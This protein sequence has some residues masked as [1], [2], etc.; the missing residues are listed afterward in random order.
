MTPRTLFLALQTLA[1]V[2]G[3]I[4]I[5][6]LY[7][8]DVMFSKYPILGEDDVLGA[9]SLVLY[10]LILMPLVKYVL[11]VLWANDDG[12][13]GIFAMYSLICRNA[14]VSLIPN[15]QLQA[16]KRMSSFRLK[17]PTPELER[18][19]KVKEK[20]ES[21]PL[22]KK[23][24][25]GLVLFGTA[26]FI[27][28]GVITPAMSVLSAVSGLKVGIPHASQDIVVMISIALLVV[29]YSLQRYA[30]SKIGF[31]V[32]P[33]LLIWF[34]C[35]GGIGI[36]NLSRYGPAA[37]KA[38]N[39]LYIIHF[40]GRNPFKAWL[41]LGGCLL[42][43]TGSEAIFSNLCYFPVRYVQS[44]F[45]LLV[46]P[47]L[48]LVY[49]GQ[50]AFL[51]ANQ[52]SS[53]RIF[54]SSIPSEAFWPVFLLA[55]LAALIASRT[56]TIAVF[57]CLKQSIALGC[58]PRLKIVHTSRKFMAKIYIPVV[59]WFL[60][61]SCLGFIVLF[62]ST[63]DVGNAYAIA[64]LGVMI[65]ATVYVAI[66]MLLI[67]ETTIVKVI[68]FVTTF[69]FLELIFFSSALSSVGDG[70]WALLIFAS[71]LLMIMFIWNYG[72]KLKYDSEVKQKL[73]KDLVRKL[74][75]NLGT[76]RAPGL[77]L[78]YSEIVKGVPAIFGHFLTALPAI[79]SIIVFVCIRNVPVPVVPQS[80]RFLFQRVCSRGYHMFRC[81]SR[82]GY[83]DKKQ[84]HH[85]T[86]ERL[87][88][89]GLE[90]YIQREAVEL[91]LQ[92]EDDIDSDEEP[93]TPA[94]I[95]TA[96]NGSLYSLD[97]PLLMDFAPSVEP[98]PETPCC[99]TPQ[100][101]A[102]DYTQNLELELAFIKQAKQTG[103]VYLIDNPI[104]KARKDS[105][106]FK[107]LTINYFYAFLRNNCRRA[108]VSMSIPHS[109]LLQVRLTSYV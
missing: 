92:S 7:T 75:P 93:S 88:I 57:Q 105:W 18:S 61:A 94:R 98:I 103:A 10:T 90:K 25:L 28:N 2:F 21:S 6:P 72:S 62:R 39:P 12:E 96:P 34:C 29:L 85:N 84:E 11:V 83:K 24:L 100:D 77:G 52:K 95:I 4:G 66:I 68:S 69:L 107:K 1:V 65:M 30:T 33:C 89:E 58:F 109:N 38:F 13:G 23:L 60:L 73:S 81:I 26:M 55:N 101:P 54:F 63:N 3:D 17:L 74:G 15:H 50:A 46:L 64:E 40:F 76:M 51:I 80:E 53:K 104:V 5:S 67:W 31:I 8:F 97:V 41:S 71:G 43:A 87:L 91:S 36:Y 108:V 82:Y 47:C 79:H 99:S 42:C 9:L 106:F 70:G 27:S 56:M 48:V 37:F 86:F 102:L 59:N 49:L 20:L 78:V 16:E 19:I 35:L 22:L 32:G 45:V 14:K 44:M